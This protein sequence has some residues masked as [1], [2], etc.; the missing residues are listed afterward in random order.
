MHWKLLSLIGTP[1]KIREILYYIENKHGLRHGPVHETPKSK[2]TV[3]S[4]SNL[5]TNISQNCADSWPIIH[6]WL[7]SIS[8]SHNCC[9]QVLCFIKW[10]DFC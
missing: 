4:I 8:Y 5:N 6:L 9:N 3:A 1:K 7:T 2:S 10:R